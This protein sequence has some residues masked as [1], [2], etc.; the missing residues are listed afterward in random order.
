M[1]LENTPRE[2]LGEFELEEDIGPGP[3]GPPPLRYDGFSREIPGLPTRARLVQG[4]CLT[5]S[6]NDKCREGG[7][8]LFMPNDVHECNEYV[9]QVPVYKLHLFGVLSNGAK[10]HV[11]LDGIEVYFDVLVPEG[12][13]GEDFVNHLRSVLSS[14]APVD[15]FEEYLAFPI[16]GFRHAKA[17]WKRLHFSNLQ[18]RKQAL[19]AVRE[20]KYETANDDRSSYYRM[21]ARGHGFVLAD[22]GVLSG[23]TYYRGGA[24][25]LGPEP[26]NA[27]ASPLCEHV[28]R[29]DVG[30]FKPL[31]D[32][33]APKG[34]QETCENYKRR[35]PYLVR[36]R[37]LVL[38]W[39][40]ETYDSARTGDLPRASNLQ[41]RVF[42]IGLTVHWKDDPLPLH[43]VVLVDVATEPDARWTTVVCETEQG[44]IKAFAVVCRH[45]AP[46]IITGFNDG[47]YDWPY[48][49][50]RAQ[51]YR[52]LT[53]MVETMSAFPRAT[54]EERVLRW[55]VTRDKRVKIS[56]EE[57]A[58]VT[59]LKVP[60][61]VPVDVR[62]MFR[63]LFPKAEVGKGSFL[64]FYLKACNLGA[65]ADM[66]HQRMWSIYAAQDSAQMRHVAHYCVTDALRCQE[67]LVK[68]NVINENRE[69]AALSYV[70]LYDA[71]YYA[72]G[73]KVCNML[74]AYAIRRGLACSNINNREGEH[75]KYPG[76]WVFHPE[77]GLT[78]DPSE[79]GTVA[80]EAARAAYVRDGESARQEV[81]AALERYRPGRPVTG[82]DF[83]S[84]YPSIIM[85]YNLSPEKFVDS[86]EKAAQLRAAGHTLHHTRFEYGGQTV[87]GWFVR[88]RGV[89]TEYGLYPSILLDLGAKRSVVKKRLAVQERLKE[90]MDLMAGVPGADFPAALTA[91]LGDLEGPA[92]ERLEAV[93]AMPPAT[94]L[95]AF[96]DLYRETC[97]ECMALDSKQKALKVF[98][99]TF[100]GEAGHSISPFFLL[101]LA[102]GV[103]AAGQ[104]NIKLVADFVARKGFQLKYGDTD[105]LY[106]S[107]PEQ[108]F[109]EVDRRYAFGG[110][111]KE[112][113]W[114]EMVRITM[115]ALD[116]LRD[117][118]NDHLRADNG[119]PHLSMAYEE[120][121]YPVVFTGKKK[122]FGVAHVNVPNFHP[123]KLFIR[124]IDV[125]KQGQ[126]ELAKRIGYRVMWAAMALTNT[127]SLLSIVERVLKE[128][129]ENVEQWSFDDFVLSDAWKPDKDNKAVQNFVARMRVRV[130]EETAENARRAA[131]GHPP[132]KSLYYLPA[133]GERFRYVLVK[134][135]AAFDLRGLKVSPKKGDVMEYVDVARE[136]GLPIDVAQ[137]LKNYVIGLC[138]RFVN[139]AD[140]FLPPPAQGGDEKTLDKKSQDA[141]KK[142]LET[143]VA[144]LQQGDPETV[145]KRGYAYKRAWRNALQE[146][147]GRLHAQIGP[148][149]ES[150]QR[151]AKNS[152]LAA[153][154]S[155]DLVASLAAEAS[156]AASQAFDPEVASAYTRGYAALLGIGPDGRD[157]GCGPE[158]TA[159]KLYSVAAILEPP[160]AGPRARRRPAR[161]G[162]PSLRV[163]LLSALDRREAA[164]RERLA[165]LV[166]QITDTAVEYGAYL[167]RAV[168]V[169]RAREH[170]ANP[171]SLGEICAPLV[172]VGDQGFEPDEKTVAFLLEIQQLWY[173]LWGVYLI[174]LQ[175]RAMVAHLST[176]KAR[177]QRHV[178]GP[179]RATA[180]RVITECAQQLVPMGLDNIGYGGY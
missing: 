10:A 102:G 175:H 110:L 149:A 91:R 77:K 120:V 42:M 43:R 168:E 5:A 107:P 134:P 167:A 11:I 88:H 138:A 18:T 121:L 157:L 71:V 74:I 59:F 109:A 114:A 84:L 132:R 20:L 73:L 7:R 112:E 95:A 39:D 136:S 97:F 146:C 104:Y 83:C 154:K 139:Y 52:I 9:S 164:I 6:L 118:V 14:T 50:D 69:V 145:R 147:G 16:R 141:A 61:S 177:R 89:E 155:G 34:V 170:G 24:H 70:S 101:Q 29:V 150:L 85:A 179:D 36:D 123:K 33:M 44:L 106:L 115:A 151:C 94:Q 4:D 99:N 2:E 165:V 100:Y 53:F 27:P 21:A 58:C 142:Y 82:L 45:F 13:T 174:R 15:R 144:G 162:L 31:V 25:V 47:D 148:A 49:I 46:D 60:G 51:H 87:Q 8:I 152:L 56:A 103:T 81:S 143:F 127:E 63:K 176:L 62:V 169:W 75:G 122:Y 38:T 66:P 26:S 137:Y 65:K 171:N 158:N 131:D 3:S 64:N 156:E 30:G 17:L 32:P 128:A 79:P 68:R 93:A 108:I 173:E 125:V 12:Q 111:S 28:F 92:R 41:T 124:G 19:E 67:L 90:H 48:V 172:G 105:S 126:T 140:R 35:F 76:A 72:G 119:T 22:W 96:Q 130:A 166:S 117:Q 160:A 80:L 40:I 23:Y 153:D 129:I 37:T 133:P 55:N 78:P 57:T 1:D 135:G 54:N 180:H 178:A 86:A 98:M 113:H 163:S 159:T 116:A 161:C